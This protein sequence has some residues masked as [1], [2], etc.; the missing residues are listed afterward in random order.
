MVNKEADL[1]CV[2]ENKVGSDESGSQLAYYRRVAPSALECDQICFYLTPDGRR[3]RDPRERD[4]WTVVTYRDVVRLVDL[5]VDSWASN[6]SVRAF[7]RLYAI[8]LRRNIVLE[9]NDDFHASA[10]RIYR[11]H[12]RV[13]D[14]ICDNRDRYQID[15][16]GETYRMVR[17]AVGANGGEAT[18]S[19]LAQ[20]WSRSPNSRC[21][22]MR[23]R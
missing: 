14:L 19:M 20:Y 11:K 21:G 8:T 2:V 4:V 15:Y 7:L 13:M 1:A 16:S 22:G 9:L 18:W 17:D 23:K 6:E 5:A 10:K 12:R 3:P